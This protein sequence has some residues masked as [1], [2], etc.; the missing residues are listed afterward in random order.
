M[1]PFSLQFAWCLVVL[2]IAQPSS[3][4]EPGRPRL[5][6]LTDIGGDPDDQQSLIRLMLYSNEFDI[7]GLIA[8]ASGTPGELKQAVTKPELI[9]E[10]VEAYGTVRP[11]LVRHAEGYFEATALLERIHSG[12]PQRG[13]HAIG[14]GKDTDGSRALIEMVDRDDSRPVNISIWG[15]QTDLAQ[16]LWRVRRDRGQEGLQRFVAKIRIYDIADQ[17]GI[18]DWICREFPGLFYVLSKSGPGEDKREAAFR[19]MYLGGDQTLVSREWMESNIRQDHGPLGA[20][21][22]PRT[23]TAP[24]P[25]SATKEG[26][27]PSWF[28]FLPHSLNDPA[29]PEWGG[30]GGRFR[31][32]EKGIY[33]DAKDTV[34]GERHARATVWRWRPFFQAEF[35]ARLDWCVADD[36]SKANHAPI[37]ILN[38][39]DSRAV[40]NIEVDPGDDITLSAAGSSDPDQDDVVAHWWVYEEAS[41]H[42]KPIKLSNSTGLETRLEAPAE[43]RT[44][45]VVLELTDSGRPRLTTLRRAVISAEKP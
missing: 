1:K 26:D 27:T 17:D 12:N 30:W 38:G 4:A 32:A 14:D 43:G 11:N 34:A 13:E 19:G 24:N 36:F 8:S 15:G 21:Y 44:V 39:D 2:F 25:H 16:A 20:L 3:A 37:A 6:V 23:W 18:A 9:R 31:L 40:I 7:E 41:S 28:Y 42:E 29:H 33:R 5:V 22:P 45:H 10:I 35:Q